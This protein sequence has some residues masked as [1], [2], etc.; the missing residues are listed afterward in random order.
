MEVAQLDSNDKVVNTFLVKK[1]KMIDPNTGSVTQESCQAWCEGK[2]GVADSKFIP[3]DSTTIGTPD[4]ND[5]YDSAKNMFYEDRPKSP[6]TDIS[7][8]SW[9][10]DDTTGNWN[11]PHSHDENV[12]HMSF[13][14]KE[15]ETCWKSR[16]SSENKDGNS[17]NWFKWNNSTSAWEDTGSKDW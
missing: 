4:V 5:N 3:V 15:E 14:W 13:L 12:E 9:S 8:S 6:K 2:F 11:A 7:F 16:K 1:Q 10:L 17:G